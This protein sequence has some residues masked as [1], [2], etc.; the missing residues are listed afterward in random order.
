M[1][2]TTSVDERV[3]QMKFDNTNFEKNVQTTMTT[4]DKLKAALKF[5]NATETL[6]TINAA[7]KDV[8]FENMSN[9]IDAVNYRFSTMGIIGARIIEN[10]TD[11]AANFTMKIFTAIPNQIRTGGWARAMNVEQA[12]FQLEGLGVA[13][14]DVVTDIDYAVDGTAYGADAAAKAASSLAA[15]GVDFSNAVK[16]AAGNIE[17][18]SDMGRSLRAISGVAA[19]TNSNYSEIADIFTTISGNG[20]IMTMQLNQLAGKG[21]NVAA[22]MATAMGTTEAAVREMVH[23]GE[24]DFQTFADAMDSAFGD[25]A[26]D[27]NKTFDGSLAN[28]K[29]ALS[30]IGQDFAQTIQRQTPQVF[31]AIKDY[32]NRIRTITRPLADHI[33]T[34]AF[35]DAAHYI[36]VVITNITKRMPKL[37]EGGKIFAKYI[38]VV[39]ALRYILYSVSDAFRNLLVFLMPIRDAFKEA[40]SFD[41]SISKLYDIGKALKEF[42]KSTLITDRTAN[43][44]KE[45]L[46]VILNLGKTVI[47]ISAKIIKV[48]SPL[49]KVGLALMGLVTRIV[50]SIAALINKLFGLE[51]VGNS[52]FGVFD[53]LYNVVDNVANIIVFLIDCLGELAS[54]FIITAGMKFLEFI[55]NLGNA[56]YEFATNIHLGRKLLVAFVAVLALPIALIAG[57]VAGIVMLV[58]KIRELGIVQSII[59]KIGYAFDVVST[60]L[61]AFKETVA[62]GIGAVVNFF[63]NFKMS[64]IIDAMK[65]SIDK[66]IESLKKLANFFNISGESLSNLKKGLLD[67]IDKFNV[68]KNQSTS[69]LFL[70]ITDNV[71]NAVPQI[72]SLSDVIKLLIDTLKTMYERLDIGKVAVLVFTFTTIKLMNS[73][74]SV[75]L[76]CN[77]VGNSAAALMNTFKTVFTRQHTK[78]QQTATAILMLASAL[79][80]LASLDQNNL[81]SAAVVFLVVSGAMLIFAGVLNKVADAFSLVGKFNSKVSLRKLEGFKA[82]L[83][84]FIALSGVMVSLAISLKILQGVNMTMEMVKTLGVVLAVTTIL[85]F[86]ATKVSSGNKKGVFKVGD[87]LKMIAFALAMASVGVA[88]KTLAGIDFSS[89]KENTKEIVVAVGMMALLALAISK[90]GAFNG[91]GILALVLFMKT[92]TPEMI[93]AFGGQMVTLFNQMLD[94]IAKNIN[95]IESLIILIGIVTVAGGLF[96]SDFK[97]FG[98]GVMKLA[99]SFVI[100]G[101]GIKILANIP[102]DEVDQGV[103]IIQKVFG[104]FAILAAVM[105]FGKGG[106]NAVKIGVAITSMTLCLYAMTGVIFL[107]GKMD[108]VAVQRGTDAVK[109]I[110]ICFA[111]ITGAASL[112]NGK[113]SFGTIL[114][115]V[116]GLVLIFGELAMLTLINSSELRSTVISMTSIM[117]GMASLMKSIPRGNAEIPKRTFSAIL[118]LVAMVGAIGLALYALSETSLTTAVGSAFAIKYV[119][120]A[121]FNMFDE[122]N[123]Y[124]KKNKSIDFKN[125]AKIIAVMAS[126]MISMASSLAL[127]AAGTAAS[128]GSFLTIIASAIAIKMVIKQ[129][130]PLFDLINDSEKLDTSKAAALVLATMALIPIAV[131]LGGLAIAIS[132]SNTGLVTFMVTSVMLMLAIGAMRKVLSVLAYDD[133]DAFNMEK[134]G[135]FTLLTLSIIPIAMALGSLAAIVSNSN[136]GLGT[137]VVTSMVLILA[138]GAFKRLIKTIGKMPNFD[139]GQGAALTMASLSILAIAGALSMVAKYPWENILASAVSISLVMIAFGVILKIITSI[140][141][142]PMT[143]VSI[144]IG[145]LAVVAI[146]STV[147]GALYILHNYIN[148]NGQ[149]NEDITMLSQLLLAITACIGICGLLGPAAILGALAGV[150]A[151]GGF[152][153]GLLA[154]L[155]GI[156]EFFQQMEAGV[157]QTIL[158]GIDNLNE[159]GAKIADGIGEFIGHI[160]SAIAQHLPDIGKGLS[161]FS[162]SLQPFIANIKNVDA[163]AIKGALYTAAIL[164]VLA[165]GEFLQGL[166]ETFTGKSLGDVGIGLEQFGVS[167]TKFADSMSTIDGESFQ[168]T[169]DAA[170]TVAKMIGELATGNLINAIAGFITGWKQFTNIGETLT[171]FGE[172]IAAF[173]KATEGITASSVEGAVAAGSVLAG[174]MKELPNEGG[175]AGLIFGEN[176]LSQFDKETLSGFAVAIKEFCY[177]ANGI[178]PKMVDGAIAVAQKL[179]ALDPPNEGGVVADIVGDND[180]GK[181]NKE[182]LGKFGEAIREFTFQVNGVEVSMAEGAI[183]VASL[184]FSLHPPN[185]GGV[186]AYWMGDN[187]FGKFDKDSLGKFGEALKIFADSVDGIGDSHIESAKK[188]IELATLI[189]ESNLSPEINSILMNNVWDSGVE[190]AKNMQSILTNIGLAFSSFTAAFGDTNPDKIRSI[191]YSVHVLTELIGELESI[192]SDTIDGFTEAMK[193]NGDLGVKSFLEA[194]SNGSSDITPSII[195]FFTAISDGMHQEITIISDACS[196]VIVYIS[197]EFYNHDDLFNNSGNHMIAQIIVGMS[198]ALPSLQAYTERAGKSVGDTLVKAV[199]SKGNDV[200][201]AGEHLIASGSLLE[202]IKSACPEV[203]NFIESK[204]PAGLSTAAAT[205]GDIV[206][207][208][209]QAVGKALGIDFSQGLSGGISSVMGAL[210]K[211]AT[212]EFSMKTFLDQGFTGTEAAAKYSQAKKYLSDLGKE[213]G[214][215][216][217]QGELAI[218]GL[219]GLA[220]GMDGV[221]GAAGGAASSVKDF[222]Q[223]IYE[224][225]NSTSG[226]SFFNKLELKAETSAEAILDN[227]KSNVNGM[228]QWSTKLAGL[229]ERGLN[230]EMIQTL[231]EAGLDSYDQIN[232]F[233][234]MTDEQIMEANNLFLQAEQVRVTAASELGAGWIKAGTGTMEGFAAGVKQSLDIATGQVKENMNQTLDAAKEAL[235]EHSPSGEF[236]KIGIF[237]MLGFR[238]GLIKTAILQ[239]Y[240]VCHTISDTVI[241]I[242][243]ENMGDSKDGS[244]AF[245]IGVNFSVGLARGIKA[246]SKEVEKASAE[247]AEIPDKKT[248]GRLE[249]ESPSKV[250]MRIGRYFDLGLAEGIRNNQNEVE[251]A[252]N[253][254]TNSA[255]D[256]LRSA[257]NNAESYVGRNVNLNPVIRPTLDISG[258][259]QQ[260]SNLSELFNRDHSIRME[261]YNNGWENPDVRST[262]LDTFANRIG[263]EYADRVVDAINNKDMD[264]NVHLEGDAEGIFKVVRKGNRAFM[265]RTGYSG[266]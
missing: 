169:A 158:K 98:Q 197:N 81:K 204:L 100:L 78:L 35:R 190:S 159:I 91:F 8:T 183:Q 22:A 75:M 97:K 55:I 93:S 72:K 235:D 119:M 125:I 111:L 109:Q 210:K 113:T 23:K 212:G 49:L 112:G 66:L 160:A 70:E 133:L 250:A 175:L 225:L 238:D 156:G 166:V 226:M 19:M 108:A 136:T 67:L 52:V 117:I 185:Q 51:D 233:M 157:Y 90:I 94:G 80:I 202:G 68:F 150:V 180:L 211:I 219:E 184:L 135:A 259:A 82:I 256:P 127:I 96:G 198:K 260:A 182:V 60:H 27:A 218:P 181:F 120:N 61:I 214:I 12:K 172:G 1:N 73:L 18:Y 84:S 257:M 121:V 234:N 69:S 164:A 5:D 187:D 42:G 145:I 99:A 200:E 38:P 179:F 263:L 264:A 155:Y 188:A 224:A 28:M 128:G 236:E 174:L 207:P 220:D 163:G 223:S 105:S 189:F 242:F 126:I 152:V 245:M 196:S 17:K 76:T 118:A 58:N 243:T 45:I 89:I 6:K 95:V 37:S 86:I 142:D 154:I 129:M 57:L 176:S 241:K 144:L 48:L 122:I 132:S 77:K 137:F 201:K 50:G 199:N 262:F 15:S 26:K 251:S 123:T 47:T 173:A 87:A 170:L 102:P 36:S 239:V 229:M 246:G 205:L 56:I 161:D 153:S 177:Q 21:L 247:V 265:R 228:V 131:A 130:I 167:V 149:M 107:L 83:L 62:S 33:F 240:P 31:V 171:S 79:A 232:A 230:K 255:L 258:V 266:I 39:S 114:A 194:F 168:A 29:S 195:N 53:T 215:V 208:K 151:I 222:G 103:K 34:P 30:R 115:L 254:L 227:M 88:L 162:E 261:A 248:T 244:K 59:E 143:A 124:V 192:N 44:I 11:K 2:T 54:S 165:G 217:E 186:A 92:L 41:V 249:I 138:I 216:N 104:L 252:S 116:S 253:D 14:N 106:A 237:G 9:A 10:L 3:V 191:A 146:L 147:I 213:I 63:K 85:A 110:M 7:S 140:K 16:D 178:D 206:G 40:F 139:F 221:G 24:I 64:N 193:R 20:R 148:V 231:A 134:A 25:H 141:I 74:S 71:Q 43:S 209:F 203:Y 46:K 65:S 32:F 13:W 4:L 101:V